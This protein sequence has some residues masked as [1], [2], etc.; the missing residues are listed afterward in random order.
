MTGIGAI[1]LELVYFS[2]EEFGG[3]K[4]QQ[5][6][7]SSLINFHLENES[8]FNITINPKNIKG[9]FSTGINENIKEVKAIIGNNGVGKST[10]LECIKRFYKYGLFIGNKVNKGNIL[11]LKSEG[12]Y[13]IFIPREVFEGVQ[14]FFN[15]EFIK[16]E[17]LIVEVVEN[18]KIELNFIPYH[19][20]DIKKINENYSL[21]KGSNISLDTSLIF[22]N[23]QF[24]ENWGFMGND[25]KKYDFYDISLNNRHYDNP[26]T[27]N[28]FTNFERHLEEPDNRFVLN[29]LTDYKNRDI[30]KKIKFLSNL[31]NREFLDYYMSIPSYVI[32]NLD[33]ELSSERKSFFGPETKNLLR[34]ERLNSECFHFESKIYETL[35]NYDDNDMKK[36]SEK[37]FLLRVIDSYFSDMEKLI[38]FDKLRIDFKNFEKNTKMKFDEKQDISKMIKDFNQVFLKFIQQKKLNIELKIKEK[39][40]HSF[41]KTTI[42]YIEFIVYLKEIFFTHKNIEFLNHYT[43]GYSENENGMTT[44]SRKEGRVKID[45]SLNSLSMIKEF[46]SKYKSINSATEFIVLE[47]E[48]LSIGENNLFTL[49]SELNFLKNK[50]LY[51]DV[52]LLLDEAD[53]TMHPEW[54]RKFIYVLVSFLELNFRQNEIQIIFTTHSPLIISDL[55]IDNILFLN[56]LNES[57]GICDRNT[58]L[59][60]TFAANIHSIYREGQFLESTTGEFAVK[61]INEILNFLNNENNDFDYFTLEYEKN[62]KVINLIG[63]PLVQNQLFQMLRAKQK[64]IRFKYNKEKSNLRLDNLK[65]LERIIKNEI[66]LW[67]QENDSN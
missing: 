45:T 5:Y 56:K 53:L 4:N 16:G 19:E 57:L 58:S 50:L 63:E 55:P 24:D 65:E 62:L 48:P 10:L 3:I 46:F 20:R 9:F 32:F 6:N 27:V 66:L 13:N 67:E 22:Y 38:L 21:V 44:L 49:L 26:K 40:I 17:E 29:Y 7:F 15:N 8:K 23:N 12:K 36:L 61:K 42:S 51:K 54:Q 37:T 1:T 34:Y 25:N 11:V 31:L 28:Q 18:Q 64:N 33:Y 41:N 2:V 35:N 30:E 14:I 43:F 60:N 52:L 59:N 47:W 39:L